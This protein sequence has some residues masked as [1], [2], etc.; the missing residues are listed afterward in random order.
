VTHAPV[1]PERT[2]LDFIR[3]TSEHQAA[4]IITGQ[5]CPT[6]CVGVVTWGDAVCARCMGD[7]ARNVDEFRAELKE[8]MAARE[9]QTRWA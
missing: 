4:S 8:R 5:A 3:S 6:C 9:R 7:V 1:R 2:S